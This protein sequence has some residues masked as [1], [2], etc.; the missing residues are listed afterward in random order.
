MGSWSADLKRNTVLHDVNDLRFIDNVLTLPRL[1]IVM[2]KLLPVL[3]VLRDFHYVYYCS[4][5]K[6]KGMSFFVP[7][8]GSRALC[9]ID[10]KRAFSP[11]VIQCIKDSF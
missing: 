7:C 8:L 2:F 5:L 9:C 3:R 1:I 4:I 6:H 10:N 11:S